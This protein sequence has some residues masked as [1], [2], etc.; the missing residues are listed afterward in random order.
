MPITRED[1]LLSLF[2]TD[3]SSGFLAAPALF[4]SRSFA[5]PFLSAFAFARTPRTYPDDDA[6]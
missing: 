4:L 3:A 6:D 2:S 5:F 1:T